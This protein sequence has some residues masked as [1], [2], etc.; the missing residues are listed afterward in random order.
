MALAPGMRLGPYEVVAKL[1]AGGMGEVYRSRDT[2]L[3]RDVAI[4]VLPAA[5]ASEADRVSRFERE[6][7]AVAALSHP[8]ILAI[9][10]TGTHDGQLYVVTELLEGETLRDRLAPVGGAAPGGGARGSTQDAGL[11][12]RKA[13]DIA[14]QMARGLAAAHD[15]GIVHRDLKPENVFLTKDGHVKILDFGLARQAATTTGA[16]E[17]A[18]ALTDPGTVMGTVGYMAPEQVRGLAVDART[19]LFALGAVLYEM[20]SGQRAFRG[21][22]AA[23]TMFAIVK[24]DPPEL[25]AVRAD[26]P[27][28]LDR[29]VRHCL[30]KQPNERFQ[31]ARDVAFALEALSGSGG[32]IARSGTVTAVPA[33]RGRILG[34]AVAAALI[35]ISFLAGRGFA[36]V[37]ENDKVLVDHGRRRV[38]IVRP[39][40]RPD[41]PLAE[42]DDALHAEGGHGL[43]GLGVEANQP[44]ARVEEEP[45]LPAVAPGRKAAMHEPGAVGRRPVRVRPRVKRPLLLPRLGVERDD[46]VVLRRDIQHVIDHQRRVLEVTGAR[47]ELLDRLVLG[48]PF[49]G[50]DQARDVRAVDVGQRRELRAAGVAAVHR[51]FLHGRLLGV[52]RHGERR[53][54]QQ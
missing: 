18:A 9:F 4:K 2:R 28:A 7:K 52:G 16:T 46:A 44:V 8:N 17:T 40:N 37:A 30:E 10:D 33:R 11:P 53:G 24:E 27:P 26:L 49:P 36:P 38:R 14:I 32:T 13:T 43:P 23:D 29:I 25:G 50:R 41:Q 19:D 42:I 6:A 31:S 5:F 20:L 54:Q 21:D 48:P 34:I 22:T 3:D 39:L 47:A 35:P 12:V 15:K 51:P 45:Q 1:G